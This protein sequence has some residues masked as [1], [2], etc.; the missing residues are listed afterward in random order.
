MRVVRYAGVGVLATAVHYVI[1]VACVEGVGWPAWLGSGIGAAGGAQVA[2]LGNRWFTF[3]H[4]GAVRSSW[5][6]FMLTAGLGAALGMAIVGLGVRLGLYYLL[7]QGIATLA[8]MAAT[9]AV[10]RSWTFR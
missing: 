8:S 3:A 6:R 4:R 1:L 2:Y 10:N 5:P 9:Y 7:A